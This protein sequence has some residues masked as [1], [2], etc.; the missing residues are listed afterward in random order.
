[1][2][3]GE[4]G[5]WKGKR[6]ERVVGVLGEEGSGGIGKGKGLCVRERE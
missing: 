3:R 2:F 4:L 1:L 6:R 5:R